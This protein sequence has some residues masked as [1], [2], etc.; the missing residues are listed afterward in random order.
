MSNSVIRSAHVAEAP[1]VIGSDGNDFLTPGM[2]ALLDAAKREARADGYR[3]GRESASSEVA[4]AVASARQ[5]LSEIVEETRARLD[6]AIAQ[7]LPEIVS[8]AI[9]FAQHIVGEA[10]VDPGKS[11]ADRLLSA[12]EQ[13][14]DEELEIAVNPEDLE[15]L[16][17]LMPPN[18][19]LTA[20]ARLGRG[21]A[22]AAGRWARADLTLERAWK[23]IA[24]SCDA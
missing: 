1:V 15:Q 16:E 2:Q 17:Q 20:D 23:N 3:A 10:A 21:D 11:L 14:D 22:I 13:I 5:A 9:E 7:Q 4:E 19:T 8:L 6:Q 12:L 24:E 18:I